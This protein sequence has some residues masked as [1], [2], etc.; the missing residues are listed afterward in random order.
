MK[1][2]QKIFIHT[3]GLVILAVGITSILL[4][5]NSFQLTMDQKK[6]AA[7]TEHEFLIT[8]FK[9]LLL[10][11]RLRQ[12][13]IRLENSK[14]MEYMDTTFEEE[15]VKS[16]IFFYDKSLELVFRNQEIPMPE[17]L[18]AI[19]ADTGDSY[20]QMSENYLY[21]ASRESLETNLYYFVTVTDMTDTFTRHK[22]M[23]NIVW[24]TGMVST[25]ITAAVLFVLM[26]ILFMPLRRINAGTR[27]IAQ[28]EYQ[29]RVPEKGKD[30]LAELA[31]N[32]NRMAAAV[33][34]NIRALEDVTQ[35][36]KAFIDNLAHEM[37]TPLTSIL[38][39]SGLLQIKKDLTEE[40]RAEYVGIIKE[41]ASRM[42]VLSG[43][44]ME[45][46][47]VGGGNVDWQQL[48]VQEVFSEIAASVSIIAQ[49]HAMTLVCTCEKGKLWMDKELMKSLVYNLTDNAIKASGEGDIITIRGWFEGE[50]FF[51]SVKDNGIGI[52]KEEIKKITQAFYM[53]DKA[54]SRASGGAG[55]GLALC[56]E[57]ARLHRGNLRID[58]KPDCGT[59]VTVRMK[60][61]VKPDEGR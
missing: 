1:L 32:M 37:K 46:I 43:K 9:G 38:G 5:K 60:G 13:Q 35:D 26:Q 19:V 34:Q 27:A 51:F 21:V 59:V 8:N 17:E 48:D 49:S 31:R 6:Q 11:E 56:V 45:L 61:G 7:C 47:T 22:S 52:P 30:E 12:N 15:T 54:R 42:R 28:G 50:V 40:Q 24:T 33:E 20:M 36:Q 55:M 29:R 2:W 58:S 3:L 23:L 14:I 16:G 39:F 53:V 57:I 44:L 10:S 41:E 4:L 25:F 18:L